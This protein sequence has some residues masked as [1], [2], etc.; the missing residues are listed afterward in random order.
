MDTPRPPFWYHPFFYM[1][2]LLLLVVVHGARLHG[3]RS[4]R[5]QHASRAAAD[6]QRMDALDQQL[7]RERVLRTLP[8]HPS[9]ALALSAL[10]LGGISLLLLGLVLDVRWLWRWP[11]CAEFLA[12]TR[13][14]WPP[15]WSLGD[16]ARV[17]ILAAW[18]ITVFPFVQMGYAWLLRWP[19]EQSHTKLLLSSTYLS[20]LFV[21]MIFL[22]ALAKGRRILPVIGLRPLPQPRA[23]RRGVLSY[24][25]LVPCMA[26]LLLVAA[27]AADWLGYQPPPHPLSL[28]FLEDQPALWLCYGVLFT[29]LI[30]PMIEEIL[31][32]GVLFPALRG[33]LPFWQAAALSGLFFGAL[34]ANWVSFLPIAS[35]GMLLA[36]L[37]EAT[38][39]LY[40]SIA[41]HAM[42]NGIMVLLM[43]V[44][45]ALSKAAG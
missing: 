34:H 15:T 40:A 41:V 37:Y 16:L 8:A 4:I 42:H 11:R 5:P 18:W 26:A 14:R 31:F 9:L 24:I 44:Y 21:A 28:F 19:E 22:L 23:L 27:R 17:G 29:C 33:R 30:A 43:F 35:L 32:R 1:A 12:T 36:Y 38:G 7:S 6:A 3:E 2:L 13:E 39:S 10:M 45:R 25:T 20:L